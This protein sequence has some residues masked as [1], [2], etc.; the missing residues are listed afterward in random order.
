MRYIIFGGAGAMASVVI[1][2]LLEFGGPDVSITVADLRPASIPDP[3]VKSVPIDVRDENA[4]ARL[5]EGHN[6]VL[7]CVTYYLNIPVMRAALRARVPYTDLGGLYHGSLQQ[8]GLHDDFARAGV[9]ALLG[10]GSTP[11]ITNVMAGKM[12]KQMDAIF[13]V[14][15]RV[16]CMDESASG[17]LPVPYALDTVLDEFTLEPYVFQDEKAIAVPPMSGA[18]IIDF[19]A[20]V[21]RVE[22]LYTLHSEVAMFPRSFPGLRE[23]SFKVAFPQDFTNKVRF[24][25]QLGFASRDNIVRDVSPREMLL[26]VAARQ[27]PPASEPRD[28]D[29]IRV[30][31]KGDHRGKEIYSMAEAIVH[32][33]PVW[34]AP[35]GALDTGV[36]LSIGG[37]MLA[38]G[39]INRPG[40]Q[41]PELAVP[42]EEFFRQLE[43]RGIR[44]TFTI[45]E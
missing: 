3:R 9:T 18:E 45:V 8:F 27:T 35:A 20:P 39:A 11:G 37:Q 29:V 10:M 2:D 12:N 1:R 4:T 24:L 44:T 17:A 34:K 19:P 7:N 16:A 32:P 41:C 31:V 15:V 13:E 40:V 28:C 42:H 38:H 6:A 36:P 25:V 43:L 23:A 22:A 26:A 30:L 5:I 21:G 33:H 14:H